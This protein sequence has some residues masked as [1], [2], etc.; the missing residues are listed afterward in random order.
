PESPRW[1]E[2]IG[3]LDEAAHIVAHMESEAAA[4]GPIPPP[5][6]DIDPPFPISLRKIMSLPSLRR[7]FIM[8]LILQPLQSVG[9]YSFGILSVLVLTARGYSIIISLIYIA[10]SY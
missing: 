10:I 9:Y 4:K 7:R 3:Q 1:L 6:C 2:S 8:L 5:R